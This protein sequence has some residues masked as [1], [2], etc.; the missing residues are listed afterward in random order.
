MAPKTFTD[1][2]SCCQ[3]LHE[4]ILKNKVLAGSNTQIEDIGSGRR[5]HAQPGGGSG[6][7]AYSGYFTV[8]NSGE[9]LAKVVNGADITNVVC[10]SFT[11]GSSNISC[12]ATELTITGDEVVYIRIYWDD[13]YKYEFGVA[14]TLPSVDQEIY[15][16]LASIDA[17]GNI[18]QVW[19]DGTI[20]LNG[21]YWC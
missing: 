20:N 9:N 18:S 19:T 21:K 14:E 15:I 6:S 11:A 5:V 8:I 13:E 1:W 12:A 4:L 10:G 16:T 7:A 2:K 3:Y 17:D